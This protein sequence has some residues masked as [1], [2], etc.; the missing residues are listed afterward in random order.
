[1]YFRE[2]TVNW[3]PLIAS[4]VGMALGSALS[5]YTMSLFGP[6]LIEEFGWARSQFALIGTVPLLFLAL[7]PFAGRFTDR[8][9]TR[10]AAM[11][12]FTALPLGFV[13]FSMMRGD[14]VEFFAIYVLQHIFAILTTSMVFCRVIVERF[15]LARGIALSL[16]MSAPPLA[17]AFAAPTLGALIDAEG[18]R[19]GYLALAAMSAAG[20]IVAIT[21]MGRGKPRPPANSPEL[22]LSLSELGALARNR[23]LILITAGMF[24]VNLPQV[25][26]SSQLKLI[27]MDSGVTSQMGTW[28]MSFYATGVIV[29]RLLSGLALDRIGAHLVAIATLGLPAIGYCILASQ[30]TGVSLLVFAVFVIG[31]AQG[32][33]S[34]IGAYLISRRFDMKNFSFLLSALT[35]MIGAGSAAGSVVLSVTLNLTD[36]YVPFLLFCAVGTLAGAALFGLTGRV[37][38]ASPGT[39]SAQ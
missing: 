7:I 29:G 14:I 23:T 24:L 16:V 17:G 6:A 19:A 5:H 27:V 2:L 10:I 37:K 34:D 35:A 9:G 18:W 31:F 8:F 20:G 38:E 26:A 33:E 15:D 28:M 4:S 3:R 30:L 25:F 12:G 22:R 21:L 13:A 32:A 36:S 1:M 39:A 11:V